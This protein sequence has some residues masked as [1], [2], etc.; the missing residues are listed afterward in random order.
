MSKKYFIQIPGNGGAS[1]APVAMSGSSNIGFVG[2]TPT[3][4]DRT[5]RFYIFKNG[6]K[7]DKKQLGAKTVVLEDGDEMFAV[8]KNPYDRFLGIYNYLINAGGG[9]ELD[10]SYQ[11]ILT[12]YEGF[13]DVIK[14]INIIK[15]KIHHFHNQSVFLCDLNGKVIVNNLIKYEN[16]D[17]ELKKYDEYLSTIYDSNLDPSAFINLENQEYLTDKAKRN[18]YEI[19]KDDFKNFNYSK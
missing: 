16:L 6:Q 1:L 7:V 2:H 14:N 10:L 4:T 8:V 13:D 3:L 15:K 19:Y 17:D 12:S 18:L 5:K 9:T 11:E